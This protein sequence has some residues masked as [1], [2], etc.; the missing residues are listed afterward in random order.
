M[1]VPKHLFIITP[2]VT[3]A[4]N[5]YYGVRVAGTNHSRSALG[6]ESGQ[7]RCLVRITQRGDGSA[8]SVIVRLVFNNK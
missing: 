6:V 2:H 1:P 7:G 8:S 5:D 4:I 3:F